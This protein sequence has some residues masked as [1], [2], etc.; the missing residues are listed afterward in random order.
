M[1]YLNHIKSI[2]LLYNEI[3]YW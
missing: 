3:R 2:R 1:L